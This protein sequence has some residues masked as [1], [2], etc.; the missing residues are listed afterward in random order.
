[1]RQ[2]LYF[3]LGLCVILSGCVVRTYKLTKDRVD[4]DLST[5]NQGYL[6]GLV[7]VK[8]PR[9]K[10][11]TRTTQVVEVEFRSPIKFRKMPKEEKILQTK[12]RVSEVSRDKEILGNRGYVLE[13][14][15]PETKEAAPAEVTK[16]TVKKG[17][18][19]EKIS[20]KFYGTT[21]KW[22]KIFDANQDILKGSNKIYPGQVIN[23]PLERAQKEIKERKENLK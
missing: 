20:K 10:K 3:L 1:M 5:G 4:Q 9:L 6:K 17:D 14:T 11:A 8:E 13:T 22:K 2:V 23:L 15:I 16:Y 7:P 12:E 21:K 18:T 19:L